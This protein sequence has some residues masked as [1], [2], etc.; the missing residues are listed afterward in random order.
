MSLCG[1]K[2]VCM[3]YASGILGSETVQIISVKL[4]GPEL[5]PF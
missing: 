2:S 5:G 4:V 3:P 1:S